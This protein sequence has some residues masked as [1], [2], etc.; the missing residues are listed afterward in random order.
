VIQGKARTLGI[1]SE[2]AYRFERGVDPAGTVDALERATQL[3]LEICGGE[4]SRVGAITESLGDLPKRAAIT[5]RPDRV[6]SLLGMSIPV[7]QMVSILTRLNC[8][9]VKGRDALSVT[10]PSYRF[11]LKIEEDFIEEIARINGY[12]K[13]PASP[14]ISTLP[15]LAVPEA[16]RSRAILR[17][18][19]VGHGYHEAINYSF[20]PAEWEADFAGNV[21]PVRVAN[22]ISSQMSV[23]R[24]TLFGGLIATLR[25]NLNRGEPR[26][27][28]FEMGRCF[29]RDVVS[30]DAQPEQLGGMA[31]GARF[32][33][34]W[35][36]GG[37]NGTKVD[38]YS[39][40]GDLETLLNNKALQFERTSHPAL[41]PGR[42]ARICLAGAQV[43][44]LGELHP[45]LQQKYGLPEAPILFE[46]D[47]ASLQ[48]N[49]SPWYRPISRMQTLRRDIAVVVDD[50]TQTQ[51]LQ[52]AVNIAKIATVIDFSPFD[53]YRGQNLGQ[54]KKSV[55]FR[56]LMQDTDRTLVD[57]EADNN[58]AEILKVLNKEF[59]ATLRK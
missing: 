14:P 16:C 52:D 4:D 15:M 47:L 30:L 27:K 9:V 36:E 55:A 54:G 34:Q 21:N 49:E 5:V 24:S 51:A 37:Q 56:I 33:E 40:K 25:H 2:A 59:G 38:F 3:A 44:I 7:S 31:Y 42:S 23:M 57:S 41:H 1:N 22:P 12:E 10:A 18:L 20:T 13:L 48:I 53:I 50:A 19:L 11:D 8:D 43:G 46:L 17:R 58:V 26:L 29:L 45:V 6:D 35:G 32:P 39:V 28:I